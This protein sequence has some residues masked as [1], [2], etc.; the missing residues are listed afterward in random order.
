MH[1]TSNSTGVYI[2]IDKWIQTL[3]DQIIYYIELSAA[4]LQLQQ[5]YNKWDIKLYT[6]EY[7]RTLSNMMQ[8]HKLPELNLI[9]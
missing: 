9:E 1:D 6:C 2:K 5:E 8:K 7:Y 3:S 4:R